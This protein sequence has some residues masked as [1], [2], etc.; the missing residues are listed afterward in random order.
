[1]STPVTETAPAD[2]SVPTS[3]SWLLIVKIK[4]GQVDALR[5]EV[6]AELEALADPNS[7]TQPDVQS[8]RHRALRTRS[9]PRRGPL[10]LRQSLRR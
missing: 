8:G 1:M 7:S 6:G 9:D 2:T 5:A 10:S 3:D 4:P